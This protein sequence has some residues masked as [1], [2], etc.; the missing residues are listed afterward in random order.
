MSNRL[1]GF[2]AGQNIDAS[3]GTFTAVTSPDLYLWLLRTE[4][5]L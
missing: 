3:I 5:L 1:G 4:L 2:I